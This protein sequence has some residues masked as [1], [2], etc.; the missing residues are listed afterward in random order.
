MNSNT[1]SQSLSRRNVFKALAAGAATLAATSDAEAAIGTSQTPTTMAFS[2]STASAK[3]GAKVT[4]KARLTRLDTGAPVQSA[5]ITFYFGNPRFPNSRIGSIYT[6]AN[7]EASTVYTVSSWST[8][9]AKLFLAEFTGNNIFA[10][11]LPFAR[12]TVQ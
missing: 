6:N 1:S 3:A 11:P 5:L 4:L 10:Q 9:G 2:L 7:G 8:P 12:F